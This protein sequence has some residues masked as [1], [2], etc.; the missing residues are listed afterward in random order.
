L[1]HTT[2][3]PEN[4][5]RFSSRSESLAAVFLLGAF[6]LRLQGTRLAEWFALASFAMG[7]LSKS[8]VMVFLGISMLH[9][10]LVQS[11]SMTR[12]LRRDAK[13]LSVALIYMVLIWNLGFLSDTVNEPV[14]DLD[15]QVWTQVKALV[16]YADLVSMPVALNVEQQFF[17]SRVPWEGAVLA[18]LLLVGSLVL[19]LG[20]HASR[21]SLFWLAWIPICLAPT[22]VVPLNVLVNEHRLYLPLVAVSVLFA[23][24]FEQIRLPVKRFFYLLIPVFFSLAFQRNSVWADEV[25]LWSAA[26]DGSPLMPRVHV[27]LGNVLLAEGERHDSDISVLWSWTPDTERHAPTWQTSITKKRSERWIARRRRSTSRLR[28]LSTK[29]CWSLIRSIGRH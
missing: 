10:V 15:V 12:Q 24:M 16:K 19:L 23:R 28:P 13:F 27:E 4:P 2:E 18:S 21:E 14:R 7:L 20:R 11:A 26:A 25:T 29:E 17:E 8:I 1:T 3:P 5:G 22:L 6:R 9:G